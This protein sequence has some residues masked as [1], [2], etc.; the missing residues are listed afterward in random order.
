MIHVEWHLKWEA[1]NILQMCPDLHAHVQACEEE[2]LEQTVDPLK[3]EIDLDN[4]VNQGFQGNPQ[5]LPNSLWL[6]STSC[7]IRNNVTC[8]FQLEVLIKETPRPD[9][10]DEVAMP[11]QMLEI[12]TSDCACIYNANGKC[13]GMLNVDRLKTL[14]EA[15][16]AAKK[17]DIHAT[18]Q[19]PVQDS[20]T[21]IMGLLSR[22]KA[23]QKHL[24]QEQNAPALSSALLPPDNRTSCYLHMN[25][26]LHACFCPAREVQLQRIDE[27]A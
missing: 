13:I 14:L 22:Q 7:A 10:S 9:T 27:L 5:S 11:A 21:E 3:D 1:A 23:K 6:S 19:P 2:R 24:C 17:A 4:F 18:I 26:N 20:A 12:T 15:H 25:M 16:K 8:D